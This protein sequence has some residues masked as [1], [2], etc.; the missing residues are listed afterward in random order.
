M[1]LTDT[2]DSARRDSDERLSDAAL[3]RHE[4]GFAS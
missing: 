2:M 3:A 1:T 4:H